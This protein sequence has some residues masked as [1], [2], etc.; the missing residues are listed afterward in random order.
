MSHIF[1]SF[2]IITNFGSFV[3]F[4]NIAVAIA[5]GT[6]CI[7]NECPTRGLRLVMRYYSKISAFVR[8]I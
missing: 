5:N 3:H 8:P 6:A 4:N 7:C 2:V 1:G